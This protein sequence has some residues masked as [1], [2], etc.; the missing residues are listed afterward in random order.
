MDL[1]LKMSCYM[2]IMDIATYS[3]AHESNHIKQIAA[4][5]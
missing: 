2:V 3:M 1:F 4:L 5:G